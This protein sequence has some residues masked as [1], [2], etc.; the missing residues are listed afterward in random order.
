MIERSFFQ[1]V[2][3]QSPFRQGD[4]IRR[5]TA[6]ENDQSAKAEWG[7]VVTADCDIAQEKM[8]E[9]FT[10]LVIRSARE[11]VEHVW[12]REEISKIAERNG[13]IAI[14]LIHRADQMRDSSATPLTFSE[15][16]DWARSDSSDAI[17][18][19]V[20]I[21]QPAIRKKAGT[22]IEVFALTDL[23]M[24]DYRTPL[25]RLRACWTR[26]DR[27]EPEQRG[28]VQNAL[29]QH[30]MRT[31]YMLTPTLPSETEIGFV[32]MLRDIRAIKSSELFPSRLDRR[33]GNGSTSSMYRI[34]RFSDAI[35]YAIAQRMA[36]LFSRIGMTEQFESEC[37][38]AASL[39]LDTL[40]PVGGT[41]ED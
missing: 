29:R 38:V 8:G 11:Y 23:R 37:E 5:D 15:L 31:E 27:K 32:V 18:D 40:I 20:T 13:R 28:L 41:S 19:A 16:L 14:D 4:V 21:N 25:E 35:R 17:L 26:G 3:D 36:N 9:F 12:A 22:A 39:I 6:P 24:G 34:G 2:S 30:Q 1:P 33:I 10:Y 7:V